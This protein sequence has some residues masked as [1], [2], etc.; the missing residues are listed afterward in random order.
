VHELG[1]LTALP[2]NRANASGHSTFESA[3]T[4]VAGRSVGPIPPDGS[5]HNHTS[6]RSVRL[7]N[8]YR[9]DRRRD[10]RAL[11]KGR[12][13]ARVPVAQPRYGAVISGVHQRHFGA[14][15]PGRSLRITSERAG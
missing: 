11:D 9:T 1:Q 15:G 5:L 13:V 6:T 4:G 2:V 10:Y 12:S 7:R 8:P 14:P 3:F